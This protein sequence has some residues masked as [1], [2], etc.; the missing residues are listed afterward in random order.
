M[1]DG[2]QERFN[3][4]SRKIRALT[5]ARAMTK[6]TAVEEIAIEADKV[7]SPIKVADNP[8]KLS[9]VG[10]RGFSWGTES[11]CQVG[12]VCPLKAVQQKMNYVKARDMR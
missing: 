4:R 7:G 5:R 6:V 3:M 8:S 9:S 12:F 2:F 11:F 1:G 10:V